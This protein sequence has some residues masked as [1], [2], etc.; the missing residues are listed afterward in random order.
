MPIKNVIFLLFFLNA[1]PGLA[2]SSA[3]SNVST[4]KIEAPQLD[5][6]RTIRIY[7]PAG[8][9]TSTGKLPGVVHA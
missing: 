6:I 3:S 7:L 2:Q 1:I 9:E 8:Y 5:T 4:F